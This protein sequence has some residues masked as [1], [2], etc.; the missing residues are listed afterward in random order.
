MKWEARKI[1]D[2]RWGVF[3]MQE[4]CRTDEPVCYTA[5]AGPNAEKTAR[6]SAERITKQHAEEQARDT[7][8]D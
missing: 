6:R 4:F 7:K 3:L 2:N 1:D 8:E 5:A